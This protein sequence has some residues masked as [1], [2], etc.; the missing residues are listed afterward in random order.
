MTTHRTTSLTIFGYLALALLTLFVCFYNLETGI[1]SVPD[2]SNE[3]QASIEMLQSDRWWIP[4]YNGEPYLHKPPLKM[5]M[6]WPALQNIPYTNFSFR[7]VD[8]LFGVGIVA[9][10]LVFSLR[11]F[12]SHL[13]AFASVIAFLGSDIIVRYHGIRH[14]NQDAGLLFFSTAALVCAWPVLERAMQGA[15]PRRIEYFCALLGG[16]ALACAVLTK[17]AA[18]LISLFIVGVFVL[19]SGHLVSIFRFGWKPILLTL[20]VATAGMAAYFVPVFL[21]YDGAFG[22]FFNEHVLARIQKGHGNV[23][24]P[25]FYF[26]RLVL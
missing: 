1:I 22:T 2:E 8:A 11:V 26:E 21:T 24:P 15:N 6:M 9:L 10:I 13:G 4:T 18:G 12:G 17:S 7:V 20:F 5:W 19:L 23:N 25:L 3:I 14:A 16:L